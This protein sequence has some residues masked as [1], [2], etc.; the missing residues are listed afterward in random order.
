MS[1]QD[2]GTGTEPGSDKYGGGFP[3]AQPSELLGGHR[4]KCD[5]HTG[6]QVLPGHAA[7]V[8]G[9]LCDC[10]EQRQQGVGYTSQER[11]G[12]GSPRT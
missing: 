5:I 2:D 11:D 10:P 4:N 3:R 7:L 6:E 8:L 12:K 9:T 1:E